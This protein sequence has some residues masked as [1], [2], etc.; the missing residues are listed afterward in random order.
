M[1]KVGTVKDMTWQKSLKS[2]K[3]QYDC[4]LVLDRLGQELL[5][6][7]KALG[8]LTIANAIKSQGNRTMLDEGKGKSNEGHNVSE[9]EDVTSEGSK[10]TPDDSEP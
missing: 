6:A 10:N 2:F 9:G 3:C 7:K 8:V 4:E 1:D 5:K